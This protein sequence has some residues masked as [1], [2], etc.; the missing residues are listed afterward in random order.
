[1]ME[2][3]RNAKR[4]GLRVP[5]HY[6]CKLEG[7]GFSSLRPATAK[8]V[9]LR[10]ISFYTKE[11]I[12]INM[13]LKLIFPLAKGK[14]FSLLA[15]VVRILL[16]GKMRDRYSVGVAVEHVSNEG[17]EALSE[18]LKRHD[19]DQILND[20]DLENVVDIHF[21]ADFPPIVKKSGK[22]HL[23]GSE[24]FDEVRLR[25]LLL[26]CLS[27]RDYET[28]IKNGDINFIYSQNQKQRFRANLH[29]QRNKVEGVFRVIKPK[30]GSFAEA[31][32]PPVVEKILGDNNRGLI[33]VAGRTGSGKSTTL[34]MMVDYFNRTRKAIVVCIENPVE[35][36]HTNK[37]CIIKQR[38]VGKDTLSFNSAVKNSLR[39][40][41]DILMIGEI[42]D[43]E[44][45]ELAIAAAE[46]GVLVVTS[47]HAADTMQCLD[48]IASFFPADS[49]SHILRR[50]SMVLKG[51]ITQDLLPSSGSSGM[52]LAV[53]ILTSTLPLRNAIR[54][55]DWGKIPDI[56]QTN[57]KL[58]MVSM[59]E[60]IKKLYESNLIDYEYVQEYLGE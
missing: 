55:G 28:F 42:L 57:K 12:D 7:G 52:A 3:K 14:S 18:F 30:V 17:V 19:I 54:Q 5:I 20:L 60:S 9:S 38:E 11:K 29:Y 8:D 32:V 56:I 53:E 23:T 47:M 31:G 36:L 58:G 22:L 4:K 40:S 24:P 41:P 2:E 49:Q 37:N 16:A 10:G 21:A 26:S 13:I 45:L 34:S 59:R 27:L 46:S 33:M 44:T 6:Q 43:K 15:K 35:F 51:I 39:Q 1:M 50:L 25:N 48:R